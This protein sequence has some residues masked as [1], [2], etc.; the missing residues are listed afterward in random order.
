MT[1]ESPYLSIY[2]NTF[3]YTSIYNARFDLVHR[4]RKCTSTVANTVLSLMET[5]DQVCTF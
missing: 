5:L 3:Y 1:L 2:E 4:V